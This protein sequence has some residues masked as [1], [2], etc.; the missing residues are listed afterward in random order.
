M[1]NVKP[2]RLPPDLCLGCATAATQIEGG[3]KN[4]SWF[5]WAE[6]KGHIKD[7]TSPLRANDHWNR[8]KEDLKLMADLGIKH[9]RFSIEWSRIEPQRNKFSKES[10]QHY[11]D[12]LEYMIAL[13]IKP[14]ITLHHFSN[15]LWFEDMG[16]FQHPDSIAIFL[17]YVQFAV[18]NLKDLC[19]EYIT[20][21]E[22]NVYVTGGYVFGDWPPGKKSLPKAFKVMRNLTLCHLHAYKKIHEIIA[23]PQVKVGFANHLRV[24]VPARRKNLLD[25]IGSK[26][27]EYLFQG[28]ITTSM[29]Q[30]R[31][32]LP[33]GISSPLGKGKFYDFIGINYYSRTAVKGFKQSV[34]PN[35]PVNDLG[36]EIYPEG[37]AELCQSQYK[38]FN[39]PIWITENGTCDSADQ[40][41]A[42]FIYDH[43]EQLAGLALPIERYYHWTFIDNFEWAEGE[44]APFGLLAC[45]Y[46]TQERRVRKSAEFYQEIINQRQVTPPMIEKYLAPPTTPK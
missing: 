25:H 10:L 8:Y 23:S 30:G 5:Q 45:N 21:N 9:Y 31:L 39:A 22:P 4:N 7:G 14:L 43:L 40:F 27:M 34:L 37:I 24:F 18:S 12:E 26:V 42:R 13:G 15:P 46:P 35:R 3:D 19:T 2:F 29:S 11:R 20:I 17:N 36:W 44:S 32:H 38:K 41:R 1:S 6:G 33:L 16:A 28:A